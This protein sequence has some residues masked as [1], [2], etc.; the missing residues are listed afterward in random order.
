M[1]VMAPLNTA[2]SRAMARSMDVASRIDT[3]TYGAPATQ[4]GHGQAW[5]RLPALHCTIAGTCETSIAWCASAMWRRGDGQALESGM[6]PHGGCANA[7]A[8]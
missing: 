8:R 4:Q 7:Q 2:M 5:L 3:R 6:G 1:C